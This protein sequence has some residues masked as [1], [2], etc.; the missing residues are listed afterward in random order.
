MA[1]INTPGTRE[2]R[3]LEEKLAAMPEAQA[4]QR[5]ERRVAKARQAVD[6]AEAALK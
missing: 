4:Y 3:R 2:A 6:E 1:K 5:Q